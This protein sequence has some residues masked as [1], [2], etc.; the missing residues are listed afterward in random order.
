MGLLVCKFAALNWGF[1]IFCANRRS[2]SLLYKK[3]LGGN[4]FKVYKQINQTIL[5]STYLHQKCF[6]MKIF[7]CFR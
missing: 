3:L 6:N 4:Q 7:I 1:K 2:V 5:F